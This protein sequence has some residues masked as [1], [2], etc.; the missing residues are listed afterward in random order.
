MQFKLLYTGQL[1]GASRNNSRFSHKHD[2]RKALS[3]QLSQLWRNPGVL[4]ELAMD[5]G[6]PKV[7]QN[8][9]LG[10]KEFLDQAYQIGVETIANNWLQNS[11]RYVPLVTTNVATRCRI[12]IL[13]LR[14]GRKGLV[15]QG[16]DIDNRIKTL[17]DA[18]RLPKGGQE[19]VSDVGTW[20]V[21]LEDDSL[22]SDLRVT[23]DTLLMLPSEAELKPN[24]V[25]LVID[26]RIEGLDEADYDWVWRPGRLPRSVD[27]Q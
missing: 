26:V 16:G 20:F 12:D 6:R 10:E 14:P 21:L 7:N 18:F 5:I 15:V 22:I 17:F 25:F 24:D 13:F 1:L 4:R 3:P 23:T 27:H 2:I 9:G 8:A 11:S 19:N